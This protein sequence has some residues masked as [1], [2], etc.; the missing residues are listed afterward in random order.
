MTPEG[1]RQEEEL[2]AYGILGVSP[3][4]PLG[5]M[6]EVFR[7]KASFYHPDKGGDAAKFKRIQAAIDTIRKARAILPDLPARE[8]LPKGMV[9]DD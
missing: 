4:D 2:D 6:E 9:S 7:K 5:L 3:D 8:E 1:R